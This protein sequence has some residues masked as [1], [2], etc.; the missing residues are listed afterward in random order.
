M[1]RGRLVFPFLAD[2]RRLDTVAT[3]ADPDGAGP[4]TSGYDDI[5]REP[6]VLIDTSDPTD[7]EGISA[8]KEKA[9]ILVPCQV[10]DDAFQRLQMLMNG[11]SPAG[12]LTL[13]FHFKDLESLALVDGAGMALI[14]PGDRLEAIHDKKGNLV[15]QVITPPGLF[16]QDAIPAG[17]G[18]SRGTS[19]RNLLIVNWESRAQGV[20]R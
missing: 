6:H 8:R 9:Q 20:T 12:L 10:E 18:L 15:Q 11:N 16:V 5:Y 14:K 7:R 19:K 1:P 13:V 4:L 17:H 3:A 2:I